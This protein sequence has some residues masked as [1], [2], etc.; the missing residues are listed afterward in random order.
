MNSAPTFLT[1][2]AAQSPA[3][4]DRLTALKDKAAEA[5]D[6][7]QTINDLEERL[8]QHKAELNTLYQTVL[9]ELMDAAGVD[10]I[11]IPQD[12]NAPAMDFRLRPFYSATIAASW[13]E[14]KRAAA[15]AT[16]AKYNA[17]DLI[18]TEVKTTFGKG[19]KEEAEAFY[20]ASQSA[21]GVQKAT[22]AQSVHAATLTSWLREQV[23]THHTFLPPD[24]LASIGGAIGRIVK[25]EERK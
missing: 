1:E 19:T 23:E 22:I 2:A 14:E 12:G 4:P 5:R 21:A 20:K 9:P 13:P 11:G 15:F 18:K 10:R 7:A 17:E 3:D 16:L 6:L 25:P 8:K 24:D